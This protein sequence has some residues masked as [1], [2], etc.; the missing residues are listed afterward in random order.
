M[1]LSSSPAVAAGV[2]LGEKQPQEDSGDC[3][4]VSEVLPRVNKRTCHILRPASVS[5]WPS[6]PRSLGERKREA[7]LSVCMG[8]ISICHLLI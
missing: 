7:S 3:L 4:K 6:D 5:L 2:S 8:G 1:L